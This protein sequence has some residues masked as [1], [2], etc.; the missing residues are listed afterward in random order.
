MTFKRNSKF[1][2]F[3]VS[4]GVKEHYR[5]YDG[6][7]FY[8]DGK[9]RKRSINGKI[10]IDFLRYL[11]QSYS[12]LLVIWDKAPNHVAKIVRN[13]ACEHDIQLLF[14]PTARPE[15]NPQEQAWDFLKAATASTYYEDYDAY[16]KAVKREARKKNLTKMFPYLSH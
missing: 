15:D 6:R 8:E 7:R 14:F 9:W 1:Y 11:R 16:L 5:F 10:T 13:Y 4:N 12:K 3:G 2:A